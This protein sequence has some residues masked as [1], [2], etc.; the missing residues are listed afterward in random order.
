[1]SLSQSLLVPAEPSTPARMEAMEVE[2]G[3]LALGHMTSEV[4]LETLQQD[5][6]NQWK[7]RFSTLV[8]GPTQALMPTI[9]M[10]HS[11]K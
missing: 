4:D 7:V 9:P 3:D 10:L 11:K 8:L 2:C 5:A 1:M 6:V